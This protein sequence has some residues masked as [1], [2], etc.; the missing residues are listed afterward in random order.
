MSDLHM[1]GYLLKIFFATES[2]FTDRLFLAM[3]AL[4]HY[5]DL[6]TGFF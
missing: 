5:L 2:T 4:R 6:L 1:G 3:D